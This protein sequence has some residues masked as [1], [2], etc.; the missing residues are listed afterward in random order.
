MA[1]AFEKE[2]TRLDTHRRERKLAFFRRMI[3]WL[4]PLVFAI[5]ATVLWLAGVQ[6]GAMNELTAFVNAL[7][8]SVVVGLVVW[9]GYFVYRYLLDRN[10][11]L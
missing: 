9:G 10:P 7:V 6:S 8:G 1:A 11:L 4:P 5:W 3:W 2:V